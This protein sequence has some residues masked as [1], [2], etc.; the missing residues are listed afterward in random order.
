MRNLS[1][2]FIVVFFLAFSLLSVSGFSVTEFV[3]DLLIKD[4]WQKI[5]SYLDQGP[6]VFAT[7]SKLIIVFL[8]FQIIIFDFTHRIPTSH[9]NQ[10]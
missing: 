6:M 2:Y 9:T 10:L 4:N 8:K 1:C 7:L 3:N 5:E